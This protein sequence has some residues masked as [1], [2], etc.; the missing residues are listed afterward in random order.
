MCDRPTAERSDNGGLAMSV[1]RRQFVA[2]IGALVCVLAVGVPAAAAAERAGNQAGELG[3]GRIG[4]PQWGAEPGLG[5]RKGHVPLRLQHGRPECTGGS[6][7]PSEEAEGNHKSVAKKI[8]GRR[9]HRIHVLFDRHG[10][11]EIG[12]LNPPSRPTQ[13]PRSS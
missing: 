2:A 6:A 5:Q 11:T 1:V 13:P 12:S 10:S 9:Q 3:D 7:T 4:R 8:E